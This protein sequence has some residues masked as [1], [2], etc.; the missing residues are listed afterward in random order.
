MPSVP[1]KAFGSFRG[2]ILAVYLHAFIF[3]VY[4]SKS[5]NG[6]ST[7][8]DHM[9][10]QH[11]LDS[12]LSPIF[13]DTSPSPNITLVGI[14]YSDILQCWTWIFLTILCYLMSWTC[15][16]GTFFPLKKL[17]IVLPSSMLFAPMDVK[18]ASSEMV[19]LISDIVTMTHLPQFYC[20]I[21]GFIERRLVCPLRMYWIGSL[22]R[23]GMK[24]I[25]HFILCLCGPALVD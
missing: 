7:P 16:N 9:I 6:W 3:Y 10:Q 8:R 2:V 4:W 22:R 17:S 15:Q 12:P 11:H 20:R 18:G 24:I 25:L 5:S 1:K 14:S 13:E 23:E 21:P 19:K